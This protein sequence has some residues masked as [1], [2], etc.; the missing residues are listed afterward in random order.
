MDKTIRR[1]AFAVLIVATLASP[2]HSQFTTLCGQRTTAVVQ[3]VA[4][5]MSNRVR[6]CMNNVRMNGVPA[7]ANY[8]NNQFLAAENLR[9]SEYNKCMT[10]NQFN[11]D[12]TTALL[13]RTGHLVSGVNAPGGPN[14]REFLCTWLVER[15][16][17]LGLQAALAGY[18][19]SLEALFYNA[20]SGNFPAIRRIVEMSSMLKTNA[21]TLS[22][23]SKLDVRADLTNGSPQTSQISGTLV[24]DVSKPPTDTAYTLGT[25]L[26]LLAGGISVTARGAPLF[27][28]TSCSRITNVEGWCQCGPEGEAPNDYAICQEDNVSAVDCPAG[29]TLE[30]DFIPTSNSAVSAVFNGMSSGGHC[31]AIA[32]LQ[33]WVVDSGQEG[34]DGLPCTGDD[35][36]TG[37]G[38]RLYL[39]T[40]T[41]TGTMED[42]A[43][44]GG[45]YTS[46]LSGSPL[47]C[48]DLD[49]EGSLAGLRLVGHNM[50]PGIPNVLTGDLGDT[51]YSYTLECN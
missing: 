8:C 38:M 11:T 17:H 2:A 24:L 26:R 3:A 20:T 41:A 21:C 29:V 49:S 25:D 5:S 32:Y 27:G 12:C 15:G 10:N 33:T 51:L 16:E 34:T 1:F 19:D 47:N 46:S 35:V 7:S 36:E 14:P 40:G 48:N 37:T 31:M 22:V 28:T 9:R 42:T 4:E 44:G 43:A 18:G 6:F 50:L 13:H 23:N 30:T 45:V 39:T